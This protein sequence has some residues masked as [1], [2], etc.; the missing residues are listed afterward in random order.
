VEGSFSYP[1]IVI[2]ASAPDPV[3]RF[4]SKVPQKWTIRRSVLTK[5]QDL[6]V[7]QRIFRSLQ[8]NC[9]TNTQINNYSKYLQKW[10][11]ESIIQT[12]CKLCRLSVVSVKSS[13]YH[14]NSCQSISRLFVNIFVLQRFY[15]CVKLIEKD[16]LMA[17]NSFVHL[18][19]LRFLN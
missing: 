15:Q 16:S 18:F 1:K 6:I 10:N 9:K 12:S 13:A 17:Q 8:K 7:S 19:C 14:F 4:D 3:D 2:E 11:I 5:N